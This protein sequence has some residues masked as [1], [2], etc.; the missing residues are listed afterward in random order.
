MSGLPRSTYDPRRIFVFNL[1]RLNLGGKGR[2]IGTYIAGGIV[3]RLSRVR[4]TP[5]KTPME[6]IEFR[7]VLRRNNIKKFAASY[8]LLI[9]ASTISAHAKPPADA[10]HDTVPV[11]ISFIDWLPAIFSTRKPSFLVMQQ[12]SL[13][14]EIAENMETAVLAL[15]HSWLSDHFNPR[16]VTPDFIR[17]RLFWFRGRIGF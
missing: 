13:V 10:P 11:H 7:L 12:D 2:E 1:P 8:F 6:L 4:L 3:S 17:F 9:D 16:Q 15:V 5:R 14:G